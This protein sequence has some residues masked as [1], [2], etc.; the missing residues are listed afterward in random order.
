MKVVWT[1]GQSVHWPVDIP[2]LKPG[3]EDYAR[4]RNEKN[5]ISTEQKSEAFSSG[6]GL[7][8]CDGID[9]PN[10]G[11]ASFDGATSY[12]IGKGLSVQSVKVTTWDTIYSKYS[13]FISAVALFIVAL[14]KIIPFLSWVFS[15]L[16]SFLCPKT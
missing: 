12:V 14:E 9:P 6:F 8:S 3:Q 11:L 2:Q 5:T 16:A 7:F 10:T 4:F 1:S 15:V 13:M